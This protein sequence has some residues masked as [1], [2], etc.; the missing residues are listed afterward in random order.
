MNERSSVRD[1]AGRGASADNSDASGPEADPAF[2]CRVCPHTCHLM[3]GKVGICRTRSVRD[4]CIVSLSYGR[5]T[6]LALDPIEKKPLARFR[7][8]SLILSY[9]SYGCNMRCPFCQNSDISMAD[10]GGIVADVSRYISPEGLIN[11]AVRL[12]DC[13]NIGIAYTYNEPFIAPEYLMDC[14]VCAR[15][16]E[17]V[18][19]VVTNGYVSPSTWDAA[20]PLIDALN[21]DLK[22]YSEEGYRSLGAPGGLAAVKRSIEAAAA[23]GVHVEVTTLVVP[24]LSD[25]ERLFTEQC[26]WLASVDRS[27][28]LHLSRF[29]PAYRSHDK[30]PTDLDVLE[31]FRTIALSSLEHVY[32]G[33]V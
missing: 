26:E 1:W 30:R 4:G 20:L 23:S 33:N 32:L 14:A 5:S 18:N 27:I 21:V 8:G 16:R 9:G 25:D 13:G 11:E 24:G 7:P 19:V 29:F 10:A 2:V 28:P 17:L 12:Q 15:E 3:E 31:Q 22:C 6:A